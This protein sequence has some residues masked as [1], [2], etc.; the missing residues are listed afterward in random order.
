MGGVRLKDGGAH[1]LCGEALDVGL[2]G[3]VLVAIGPD[4]VDKSDARFGLLGHSALQ[5]GC[6]VRTTRR[7]RP[8]E[9]LQRRCQRANFQPV[10]CREHMPTDWT[11]AH[12]R[13]S[14]CQGSGRVWCRFCD[15]MSA[16]WAFIHIS[17]S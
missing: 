15:H 6:G 14:T 1:A 5:S 3:A 4:P 7:C 17:N 11:Y 8:E 13:D 9:P 2:D 10:L 12:I 16:L